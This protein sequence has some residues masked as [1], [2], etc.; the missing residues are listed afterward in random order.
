[1]L[2]GFLNACA[3]QTLC[4]TPGDPTPPPG[5]KEPWG[6]SAHSWRACSKLARSLPCTYGVYSASYMSETNSNGTDWRD[7]F[8]HL[9]LR[10]D[11]EQRAAEI[12]ALKFANM[13]TRLF[14]FYRFDQDNYGV[15]NFEKDQAWLSL[16]MDLNDPFDCWCTVQLRELLDEQYKLFLRDRAPSLIEGGVPPAEMARL[17]NSE[18]L[19]RDLKSIVQLYTPGDKQ[20]L[21]A[22]E[23]MGEKAN[24]NSIA[25]TLRRAVV[26]TSFTERVDSP[27]MWSHYAW[28]HRGFALEYDF[29]SEGENYIEGNL[30][31]VLYRDEVFDLTDFSRATLMHR[32]RSVAVPKLA[33]LQKARDWAYEKEWRFIAPPAVAPRGPLKL[34]LPKAVYLG[35][36]IDLQNETRLRA[37]ADRKGVPTFRAKQAKSFFK[38]EF[39]GR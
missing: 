19:L 20:T 8:V 16:P 17:N 5:A 36:Q 26:V 3:K 27:I 24:S 33:A 1:M 28:S 35:L 30:F 22:V 23:Q 14:K 6:D 29:K 39:L 21:D 10:P 11:V 31:P 34:P 25:E 15:A 12:R 2:D 7:Q 4:K 32:P 37:I 9:M 18:D 13:P 38:I